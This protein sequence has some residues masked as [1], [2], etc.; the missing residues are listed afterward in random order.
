MAMSV[1]EL[2]SEPQLGLELLA[3]S[4]GLGVDITW[5]HTSDLP[6]LWEWV[7]PGVLLM[8]NGLSIPADPSLQ[9]QLAQSL[10]GAGAVGLAVGEKM[11]APDLAPEFIEACNALPLP[12][13]SVPYP[14]PFMAISRSIAEATLLEESRRIKQTARIYDLLR[15]ATTPGETWTQL[16]DGIS[17]ELKADLYVLD[18]RCLHPWQPGDPKLPGHLEKRVSLALAEAP[19]ETRHFLWSGTGVDSILLMEI[20]THPHALL[21]V[22]PRAETKPDGVVLLHVA[23]VMGLGL[24]RSALSMESKYRS[25]GEFLLQAFEGRIGPIEAARRLD[26]FGIPAGGMQVITVPENAEAGL[27]ELHRTLWRHSINSIC[28]VIEGRVHLLVPENCPESLLL[29][30]FNRKLPMGLSTTVAASEIQRGLRESLWA[31]GLAKAKG[32]RLIGYSDDGSW[33]GLGGHRE[34]EALVQRLLGPVMEHDRANQTEFLVTLKAYM[35]N[36]R[37]AQKVA[38][39]LFVHRQTVIYRVRKISELTGLDLAESS[40]VGQ[41]WLALQVL[42]AMGPGER[43]LHA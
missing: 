36:Q 31:L 17:E 13:I 27:P 10:V 25:G 33:Y 43:V 34:G 6:N 26:E 23:T 38:A 22:L 19:A 7:S 5:S 1:A 42:E 11:H 2:L 14:L 39:L 3:G 37:S 29:H 21:I 15:K 12:L 16:L 8:T 9:V 35:E 30:I 4:G 32:A 20:P 18:G 28:V 40:S 24:S 41:L